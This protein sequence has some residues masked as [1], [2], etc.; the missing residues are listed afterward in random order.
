MDTDLGFKKTHEFRMVQTIDSV[1][2]LMAGLAVS[3]A[4]LH[5]IGAPAPRAAVMLLASE[6]IPRAI[7]HW[8][9]ETYLEVA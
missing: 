1:L 9:P 4:M 7:R 5:H 3:A 8:A 6:W 2:I